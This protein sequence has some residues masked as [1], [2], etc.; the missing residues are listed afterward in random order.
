MR[1]NKHDLQALAG[2]ASVAT[3]TKRPMK[4]RAEKIMRGEDERRQ[5]CGT[6]GR[7]LPAESEAG[8]GGGAR[9]EGGGYGTYVRIYIVTDLASDL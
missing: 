3:V 1:S 9:N 6:R 7:D 5:E 8:G 2:T 4:R